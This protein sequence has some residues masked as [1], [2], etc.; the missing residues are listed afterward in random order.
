MKKATGLFTLALAAA[1]AATAQT[2]PAKIGVINYQSA[3]I[4]TKDGQKA[5]AEL[6]T[7]MAPRRKDVDEK[8]AEINT[9]RDQLQKGQNTLSDSAKQEIY[10]N[11]DQKTKVLNR[12]ME[13]DEAELQQEQQ[14][15]LQD[16][17]QRIQVVVDKYAKDNG[18]ALIMDDSQGNVVVWASTAID[19][20]KEIIDLYDKNAGAMAPA[21]SS[22][23]APRSSGAGA[24][25][26]PGTTK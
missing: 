21:T 8:Q 14:R 25:P 13:D 4:G 16:L 9:L 5:A 10:R 2:T 1:L 23:P 17:S 3:I 11:I 20:T 24:R 15:L 22:L 12:A 19:I 6:E 26:A 7:K 18:F